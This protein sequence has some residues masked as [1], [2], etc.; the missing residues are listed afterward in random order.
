MGPYGERSRSH[1]GFLVP[2][3][4]QLEGTLALLSARNILEVR[5][6][7]LF[8]ISHLVCPTARCSLC[9][10]VSPMCCDTNSL[11]G[12]FKIFPWKV[13]DRTGANC[14]SFPSMCILTSSHI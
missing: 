3:D 10:K 5:H 7:A 14:R 1:S 8:L 9:I 13:A 2:R 11:V 4:K 12:R 6:T